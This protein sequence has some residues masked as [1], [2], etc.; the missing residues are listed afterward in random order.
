[1]ID[2][3]QDNKIKD[4]KIIGVTYSTSTYVEFNKNKDKDIFEEV[5]IDMSMFGDDDTKDFIKNLPDNEKRLAVLSLNMDDNVL[6]SKIYDI[7]SSSD[8]KFNKLKSIILLLRTYVKSAD[9]LKREHGEVLTPF[10]ELAKP[11]VNLVDKYDSNFWKDKNNKVLDSSAG[12]GTFLILCLYKFMEGLKNV[13]IDEDER[14]KH[15]I[16]NQLYYGEL[17]SKSVFSWLVSIDIENKYKTNIYWGS[18]L[19][20]GFDYHMKTVWGV[21][22]FDLIIQNPPYQEVVGIKK[23][24]VLW[25]KFVMKSF[26]LL[27]DGGYLNFVHPGGWRFLTDRSVQEIKKVREIYSNYKILEASF[28]TYKDGFEIFGANTDFDIIFLKKIISDGD[29][30]VNTHIDGEIKINIKKFNTIPTDNI[31]LYQRLVAGENDEKIELLYSRS[32][33]GSDKSNTSAIENDEF[34]L[35]VIYGYPL[36]GIK[37]IYSNIDKGHFNINKVILIRAST[38]SILDIDGEYGLSQYA[39]AIV[40]TD[41][42]LKTIKKVVDSDDFKKLKAYFIGVVSQN[43]NAAIDAP[44]NMFKI[45][46]EFKKDFWKEFI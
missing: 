16:E 38:N 37:T 32:L 26:S 33:Y 30:L 43:T 29:V 40:D 10:N 15:I 19:D 39:F 6:W 36:K 14:L 24:Q 5:I 28:F 13:I 27:K 20:D 42:N 7:Q 9:V 46:K 1:M 4:N 23:T 8:T 21:E 25:P 44:G 41:E 31:K 34:R 11:M 45:I 22:K 35:P 18:Y 2:I 3:T 12:Y 17:Q